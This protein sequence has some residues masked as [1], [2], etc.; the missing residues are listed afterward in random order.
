MDAK[1][2]FDDN[3]EYRQ[4]DTFKLRDWSQEDPRDAEA[5]R[6]GINYIGLDGSIGCMGKWK[7]IRTIPYTVHNYMYTCK[8]Y[9]VPNYMYTCK[10]YTVHNYM[11]TCKTYTVHNYMYT[12]KT[13]TVHNYMYTCK[14]YTVHNYT[15]TCKTYTVPNYMYTCKTYTVHNYMLYIITCVHVKC[16]CRNSINTWSQLNNWS[17]YHKENV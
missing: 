9:T 5:A 10:T 17:S 15:C 6:A 7:T 12:C 13:Y 3:A 1:I 16:M 4:K 11:C 14:T 2:N 8:T